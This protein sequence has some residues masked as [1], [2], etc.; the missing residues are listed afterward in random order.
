MRLAW[1]VSGLTSSSL[2]PSIYLI[3]RCHRD[4]RYINCIRYPTGSKDQAKTS[5]TKLAH[6]AFRRS[7]E[8]ERNGCG[9][10]APPSRT[11]EGKRKRRQIARLQAR[12]SVTSAGITA[13]T[14]AT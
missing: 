10:D 14:P 2:L 6:G 11:Q 8:A 7:N 9:M 3:A 1:P 12:D 5:L 13:T 4:A